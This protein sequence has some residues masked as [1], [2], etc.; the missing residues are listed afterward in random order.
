MKRTA[1]IDLGTN[2][3]HLLIAEVDGQ[4][5]I[6]PLHEEK[7]PARIGQGG[8]GQG[9]IT[10]EALRRG[11]DIMKDYQAKAAGFGILKD[12]ILATATSAV[13]NASNGREFVARIKAETGIDVEIISGERE[14]ELIYHGV[15]AALSIGTEPSLIVDI[16]GGSVEFVIGNDERIFWKRSFE[17]GAQRLIDRFMPTDPM[18]A[19]NVSRL[20]GFL[21]E[22]LLPL[23]NAVHQYAPQKL[24]GSSGVFD[25]LA[26]IH[27][28][29]TE[30]GFDSTQQT[31]YNL[32]ISNFR[33]V[34]Q[35]LSSKNRAQRLQIPGMIPLR[36]DMIV[37]ACC[38]VDFVLKKY[39][40]TQIRTSTYALKEGVL[41]EKTVS[42][43]K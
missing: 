21:D 7:R 8:I 25:T 5:R 24:I 34:F 3:F 32:P 33:A 39:G 11:I 18:P 22:S 38:L 42:P 20:H 43:G 27:F 16:G 13:R 10:D 36:V 41:L 14:A 30:P 35:D 1:V 29:Q 6:T 17:I 37:V 19:A 15:R 31:S 9:I 12:T 40:I 26:E 4:H 23:T 2:T 28:K